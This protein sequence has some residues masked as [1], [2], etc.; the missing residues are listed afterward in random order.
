MKTSKIK[1]VVNSKEWSN[2]GK[3]IIYHNL[4]MENGDKI[5]IGKVKLQQVGWELT[6]Q[7]TE[8]GQQEFNKAK[9]VQKEQQAYT[10]NKP[11][12]TTKTV[13]VQDL[14]VKQSSLKASVEFCN[15][16]CTVEHIIANA[17]VFY[18][19]VMTGKK[20][21]ASKNDMPF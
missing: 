11:T 18:D 20:P 10:Q 9:A 12:T 13:D 1:T 2:N 15:K 21:E 7:I 4:E 3:T 17:E 19:W 16:E 14:I 8:Q 6:Y 5:N